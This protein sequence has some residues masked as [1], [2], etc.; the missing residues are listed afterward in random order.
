MRN[1]VDGGC[2]QD[3]GI[4]YRQHLRA[5]DGQ[6]VEAGNARHG[7]ARREK[8]AIELITVDKIEAEIRAEAG[9][10]IQG[11]FRPYDPSRFQE[12]LRSQTDWSRCSAQE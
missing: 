7:P 11:A 4:A 5:P 12:T 1:S 8:Q 3:F 10:G 6:S 9:S 2:P